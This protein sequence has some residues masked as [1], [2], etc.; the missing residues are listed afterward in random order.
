MHKCQLSSQDVES[1][2]T[3]LHQDAVTFV[4]FRFTDSHGAWHHMTFHT[5]SLSPRVF[6]EGVAFDG[7]SIAGW[8]PIHDS[9]MIM[10]PDLSRVTVDPF[11]HNPTFILVCDIIDPKTQQG[12]ERDPRTVA[13]RAEAYLCATGIADRVIFGPEPEFFIF[14]QAHFNISHASGF[15]NLS[16][17]ESQATPNPYFNQNP[18][19]KDHLGH[20]PLENAGYAPVAPVDRF[21][22]IRS[23][24]LKDLKKMGIV[25][26]KHHHEVANAQHELGFECDTL[27]SMADQL[28]I[29][30]Y[31]IRQVAYQHNKTV[32]FMP[33]PVYGEN[34]SG[35]HVHQS[36]WKDQ[37]PLFSGEGYN[38][39][40]E[41]ALY[42]TGG[43]LK[44]TKAL[45]AFTNP[46]TNSYK[47]LVPGFEAPIYRA[48]SARNRS[49]AIRIPYCV[50][51]H[52]TRI[53]T[54]FPD[55]LANP[56]LALSA[57]LMAG[58][59]GIKNKIHPGEAIEEN[60][61]TKD[62]ASLDDS[63]FMATSLTQ[64]LEALDADRTFLTTGGVFTNDLIDAYINLKRAEEQFVQNRPNPAE[65]HLYYSG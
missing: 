56:Y 41:L 36:L 29:F 12:Y 25:V 44:H 3:K 9:D 33:K 58:I 30:K 13:R 24:M 11:T 60:L 28:Q 16:S 48:Y 32:T 40:S 46:S 39:L 4:D 42:Y 50:Q 22:N 19:I 15:Y 10:M 43:I 35:M 64:A 7:S 49:A 17:Q 47:R 45:N 2:L 59:D 27:V 31:A 65:F 20:R 54:R 21:E 62:H 6:Q 63:F 18:F 14:D 26:Q 53:E 52:A 38:G 5:D 55:P 37:Q 34:G 8:K 1:F 61:Y 57:L 23:D 51:N